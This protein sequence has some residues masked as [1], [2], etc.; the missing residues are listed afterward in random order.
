MKQYLTIKDAMKVLNDAG[1]R[2]T[3]A[4]LR[5]N[6]YKY[7]FIKKAP[8]RHHDEYHRRKLLDWLE[9]RNAI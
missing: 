5:Y 4:G 8:D 9:N 1:V 2:I 7:G 3:P 6:G